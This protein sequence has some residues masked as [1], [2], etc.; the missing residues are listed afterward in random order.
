MSIIPL[1]TIQYICQNNLP[2]TYPDLKP[3]IVYFSTYTVKYELTK[4]RSFTIYVR[5]TNFTKEGRTTIS[6]GS[7][8]N[9]PITFFSSTSISFIIPR[10]AIPGQYNVEI[11][12]VTPIGKVS[13]N[14]IILM[15]E[16]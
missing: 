14:T 15:I 7:Y 12:N 11:I 8:Q 1:T 13:S 6:F 2:D 10:Q 4:S 3:T 5:G 16:P 9:I